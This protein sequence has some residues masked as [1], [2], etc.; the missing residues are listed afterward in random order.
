[1][2]SLIDEIIRSRCLDGQT[3]YAIFHLSQ[4]KDLLSDLEWVAPVLGW[5]KEPDYFKNDLRDKKYKFASE[6]FS[7]K[8]TEYVEK[9]GN[10]TELTHYVLNRKDCI[11]YNLGSDVVP[12]VLHFSRSYFEILFDFDSKL[13]EPRFLPSLLSLVKNLL[14]VPLSSFVPVA[15][16]ATVWPLAKY[17]RN[18]LPERPANFPGHPLLFSGM[19]RTYLKNRLITFNSRNH[20]LFVSILQGV[21]RGCASVP[22][23]FKLE[24]MQKHKRVLSSGPGE[25]NSCRETVINNIL[26]KLSRGFDYRTAYHLSDGSTSACYEQPCSKGGAREFLINGQELK[27]NPLFESLFHNQKGNLLAMRDRPPKDRLLPCQ[28]DDSTVKTHEVY[29]GASHPQLFVEWLRGRELQIEQSLIRGKFKLTTRPCPVLKRY[30]LQDRGRALLRFIG[31]HLLGQTPGRVA[32]SAVPEPLK[33]RLVTKG[34]A[35][36][37]FLAKGAQK[38]LWNHLQ[39][40]DIFSLTGRPLHVSDLYGLIH[41][42]KRLLSVLLERARLTTKTVSWKRDRCGERL[43]TSL[44]HQL[45][46]RGEPYKHLPYYSPCDSEEFSGPRC[47]PLHVRMEFVTRVPKDIELPFKF[48]VSGDY[49]SATDKL[50]IN[51]TKRAFQ[52]FF[53]MNDIHDP[54]MAAPVGSRIFRDTLRSV[55][56]EQLIEYPKSMVKEDPKLTPF[57]QKNGQLMGSILSFPILCIV[58]LLTYLGALVEYL[59]IRYDVDPV[60]IQKINFNDLPV[61]INGDDILFR[62]DDF[63]YELWKSWAADCGFELSLGKNYTHERFL[64][65]NSR[66]FEYK[67]HE[68]R[69]VEAPFFNAGVLTGQSKLGNKLSRSPEP[70]WDLYECCLNGAFNKWRAHKRFIHYYREVIEEMT[71]FGEFSLFIPR[72]LGGLGFKLFDEVR[73]HVTFTPFQLKFATYLY[74]YITQPYEGLYDKSVSFQ[75]LV[76]DPEDRR[77]MAIHRDRLKK[78]KFLVLDL[79]K[80]LFPLREG[81]SLASEEVNTLE[82]ILLTRSLLG[83]HESPNRTKPIDRK[84]LQA[85][86]QNAPINYRNLNK[87]LNFKLCT[88]ELPEKVS[89]TTF[90]G[91]G[92]YPEYL[93]TFSDELN[94][95]GGTTFSSGN[96]VN[97]PNLYRLYHGT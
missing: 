21:K 56:Y 93:P 22:D 58:N 3:T 17:L 69:F 62:S 87:L 66:F 36:N 15:K 49:A 4:G 59:A 37:Y 80:E 10:I 13:R 9:N 5:H 20:R 96:D 19:L 16:Y 81:W 89:K 12:H 78:R 39:K 25:V 46:L 8:R 95:S 70:I 50:N 97:L 94:P 28:G 60:W 26:Q 77:C 7:L 47:R 73:P 88:I 45:W 76:P 33:V 65:I 55:L 74:G 75:G 40:F 64:T 42:E 86:R 67:P 6:L 54:F 32:V 63:H 53:P 23:S 34:Q 38:S 44:L 41:T 52:A 92:S 35:E 48:F 91:V 85:F 57:L 30:P 72:T 1:M 27:K 51:Y 79:S 24:A 2:L 31:R 29:Y 43:Y 90:S 18:P 84:L 11:V 71:N 82:K 14:S 83:H 61:L 68:D